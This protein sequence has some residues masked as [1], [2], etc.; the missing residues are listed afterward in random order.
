MNKKALEAFAKQAAKDIKSEQD[1]TDFRKI[2]TKIT[3]EAALN[4]ELEEHLGYALHEQ[5][6][7]NSRNGYSSKTIRTEDGQVDLDTPRDKEGSF[8]PQ[9]VKKIKQDLLQWTIK[10][11]TCMPKA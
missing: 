5:S 8:E 6:N 1:L 7:N 3:V 2:L 11:C 9:L 10:S 4:A